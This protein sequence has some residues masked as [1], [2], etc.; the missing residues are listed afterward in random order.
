MN[1]RYKSKKDA[2]LI[3]IIAIAFLISLLS[4]ILRDLA[5]NTGDFELRD[6][7]IVRLA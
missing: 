4:L 3:L 2:W 7:G 1:I 5:K 6:D